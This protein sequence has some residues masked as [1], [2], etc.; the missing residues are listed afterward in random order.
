MSEVS[1]IWHSV[2]VFDVLFYPF[3]ATFVGVRFLSCHDV[4]S[5]VTG[6]CIILGDCVY[7]NVNVDISM[8]WLQFV[9]TS[10]LGAISG[11]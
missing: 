9:S 7:N 4:M 1:D 6:D 3:L 8:Q 11:F 5:L 2:G 10:F